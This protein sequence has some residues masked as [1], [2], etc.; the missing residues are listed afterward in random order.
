MNVRMLRGARRPAVAGLAA[1]LAGGIL[2][3]PSG[4][5]ADDPLQPTRVILTP[6]ETPETSQAITFQGA[7]NDDATAKVEIKPAAGGSVRV[8]KA[9]LQPKS[10][11]NDFPHFSTVVSGLKPGT[12]YTYRVATDG[13]WSDWATF[14]TAD[15]DEKEFSYVY[16]GDAQIGLDTTWPEVVR[17]AQAKA[18]DSIGS[19]HAG[20]LIDNAG[21]DVQWQNWFKGMKT[22]AATTNV[23]AAPGNHEY[24]GDKLM[25][26]WK[27]HF[28]YPANNP[29]DSTIGEMAKLA[30]GDSEVAQQYRAY[31]DHWSEFAAETVYFSDYQ[32]VRFITVNA[33]RD[34]T[35]L[36]PDALPACAAADCPSTKVSA[37]WT[38]Y[39]AAW[40]DHVLTESPSKWNVVTF[41]QPVYSGS[42]GRD[43]PILRE[44]WVPVFEKHD[45]DLVQMGHDHVYSR[46][47]KSTTATST[48]GVTSGPV[49]I[50][51][52]SGAKHYDL[53][54]DE[55]NVWTNN[56]A[57]QVQKGEDFTTYQVVDV[58]EDTLTYSSYIAEVTPSAEWFKGGKK[59]DTPYQVGDLW[60]RFTVH[61]TDA[62][63]KAVVEDG[64]K[65]PVL[66]EPPA[67]D[68]AP[69]IA[70]QPKDV[71]ATAGDTVRLTVSAT[72]AKPL[73]YQWQRRSGNGAWTN[74]AG[75]R[76]ASLD[77][78]RV[79]PAENARR[80]RV[81]VAA[82]TR[83]TV[84]RAVA[85][86]VVQRASS[87]KIGSVTAKRGKAVKVSVR[88]SVAGTVT[89]KVKQGRT[90]LTKVV[91]VKAGR[92][93]RVTL[94]R[95]SRKASGQV[96]VTVSLDAAGTV[97]ADSS[98][99]KTVKV[100]R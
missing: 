41:H 100:R 16:Y 19:V 29:G 88:P 20:D 54:T 77:L 7:E 18:P 91:T 67:P 95:L 96:K 60:D 61:K 39:Q 79:T 25:T 50:V 14:G 66:E 81:V 23:F 21:N 52:N 11:S 63:K 72:A 92:T 89:V 9:Y 45:I 33:T 38:Q 26:A 1:V 42:E 3:L 37:L 75:K 56:G 65:P 98:A 59:L 70:G 27:A 71:R 15:P 4:A 5:M 80:Y 17:Q 93:I 36:T 76:S 85:V 46:G 82:G 12:D 73:T 40:L 94:P 30:E 49:Y 57:T 34:T 32:G 78:T 31:F 24:S 58:T 53:E 22:P 84:S 35:F 55:K 86:R 90:T 51:S 48:P 87:V 83:S 64:V 47:F 74:L 10:I 13:A 2:T 68:A 62:G 28:E 69:V 6:T 97:H 99:R 44:Y 43:E 8:V